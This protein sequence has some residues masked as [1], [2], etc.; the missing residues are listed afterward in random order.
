MYSFHTVDIYV[1]EF[2]LSSIVLIAKE[3]GI[4]LSLLDSQQVLKIVFLKI[5]Y[6]FVN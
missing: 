4:S 2:S 5:N 6:L 1:A 3:E